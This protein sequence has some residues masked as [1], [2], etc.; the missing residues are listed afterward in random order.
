MAKRSILLPP[1]LASSPVWTALMDS[2]DTLFADTDSTTA[3]LRNIRDPYPVSP[4]VQKAIQAGTLFDT[5]SAEYQQ[6]LSILIKQLEFVGL[7]LSNPGY[8][9]APQALLLFRNAAAYWYTKGTGKIEDFINF[10]M[11]STLRLHNLWTQDYKSFY[12]ESD[13][14]VGLAVTSGGTWYPTTHVSIDIG[15]SAVFKGV[16]FRNFISFFNDVFNYNLVL[17]SVTN[18]ATLPILSLPVAE[19]S[20]ESTVS[21][22]TVSSNAALLSLSLYVEVT[23]YVSSIT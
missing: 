9:T 11:G 10:T 18:S 3:Q 13:P 6:D 5:S 17:H 21:P 1:Y 22:S 14:A 12:R 4:L 2:V 15:D 20:P 19:V 16:A 7:P 23:Y 8:L